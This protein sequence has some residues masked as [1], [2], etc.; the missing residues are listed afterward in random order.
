MTT[1]VF[2][3]L[4]KHRCRRGCLVAA[5]ALALP[6]VATAH[7]VVSSEREESPL[8]VGAGV[9]ASHRWDSVIADS[10]RWQ[11][12][13]VLMGGEALGSEQGFT[14][15]AAS[16]HLDWRA[17]ERTHV[18]LDIGSH[19]AGEIELEEALVGYRLADSLGLQIEAGRMKARFSTEN[20]SHAYARPFSDNNLVYDAFYGGHVVDEGA[21]LMVTPWAG[22][23]LGVEGWRGSQFPAT[24]GDDGGARDVFLQWRWQDG[25][26]QVELGTWAQWAEARD[27][28][29]SR[30]IGGHSHGGDSDTAADA[31]RFDGDQDS[32]GAGARLAWQSGDWS[33][34]LAAE[35]VQVDVSGTL[36]DTTRQAALSG[37]YRGWWLQPELRWQRQ[38]LTLRYT[39][40]VLDN[41]LT[42]VAGPD[43][44]AVAGLNHAGHDPDQWAVSYRYQLQDGLGL[45]LEWTRNRATADP[46]NYLAAGLYWSGA[47][48]PEGN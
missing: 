45:R 27:R 17:G 28:S 5:M 7:G 29:D 19:H 39:K 25:A 38:A 32:Q 35:F 13:G 3:I 18:R 41:H 8:S 10:G 15:D 9:S 43:L 30:Y 21:R 42:G 11:V 23:T 31:L 33:A 14:L 47:L 46:V 34:G 6:A 4:S 26:W 12:P 22:I 48:W 20:L 2:S 37:D 44:A 1:A 40:L 36:R 24:A 16:V